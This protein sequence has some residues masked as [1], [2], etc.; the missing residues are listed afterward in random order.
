[1]LECAT[2]KIVPNI[3]ATFGSGNEGLKVKAITFERYG[4]P[5]VLMLAEMEMSVP[6]DREVLIKVRAAGVNP[7]DYQIAQ[8]DV[9]FSTG[10]TRPSQNTRLGYDVAGEI[11]AVGSK[12]T[13]FKTGDKVFGACI[14]RPHSLAVWLSGLG[15]FAEYALSHEDCLAP[16]PHNLTFEQA[17]AVP[18][19]GWVALQGLRTAVKIRPGNSVLISSATGG[20]GT[21]AVQ[22]AKA[23][24]ARVTGVCSTDN[25]ELVRSL[26]ADAVIDY[27]KQ[28][29]TKLGQRY[30]LIFDSIGEH[31]L[32]KLRRLLNPTGKVVFIGVRNVKPTSPKFLGRYLLAKALPKVVTSGSRPNLED[33]MDLKNFLTRGVIKP[34]VEKTYPDLAAIPE[35][36]QYVKDGHAWGKVVVTI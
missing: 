34:V 12:V 11:E 2:R 24:G 4:S 25:L 17:A 32:F 20:I 7:A 9:R 31:S 3:S 1:M 5:K 16:M 33:L 6:K 35:A 21:F 27:R 36:V 23:F 10:F 30:D 15:S 19:A 8:G 18:T 22:I 14:L 28:D 29:Y 13:R 26:G